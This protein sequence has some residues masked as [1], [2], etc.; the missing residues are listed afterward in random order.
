MAKS[1]W[2]PRRSDRRE[3]EEVWRRAKAKRL[4]GADAV[5]A[6]GWRGLWEWGGNRREVEVERPRGRSERRCWRRWGVGEE[7]GAWA[8]GR[9]P[10]RRGGGEAEVPSGA[11]AP[12]AVGSGVWRQGGDI[13]EA[14]VERS[15]TR[16]W[17]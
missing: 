11:Q 6:M 9:W 8:I 14:E 13:G 4:S 16:G 10:Q 2:R 12:G 3:K 1:T 15:G 7:E 5:G 17:D